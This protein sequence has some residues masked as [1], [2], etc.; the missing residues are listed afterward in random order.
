MLQACALSLRLGR[1]LVRLLKARE[2]EGRVYWRKIVALQVLNEGQKRHLFICHIE[3]LVS[4]DGAE[5]LCR[6]S[7]ATRGL[8]EEALESNETAVAGDEL[9]PPSRNAPHRNWLKQPVIANAGDQLFKGRLIH[10]GAWLV[11]VRV[12]ELEVNAPGGRRSGRMGQ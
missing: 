7:N 3:L 11:R 9:V 8:G 1:E 6:F 4:W 12:N 5:A 10:L 2:A